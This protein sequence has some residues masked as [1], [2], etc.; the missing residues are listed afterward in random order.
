M[1]AEINKLEEKRLQALDHIEAN[2]RQ[3]ISMNN[4]RVRAMHFDLEDHVLMA[5]V[6]LG[7]K[8]FKFGKWS[9]NMEGPMAIY[10]VLGKKAYML[11]DL[12]RQVQERPINDIYLKPFYPSKCNTMTPL[13]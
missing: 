5:I 10:E 3:M 13:E 2:K 8:D 9:P 7:K 12:Q 6:P 11:R 4:E 1:L